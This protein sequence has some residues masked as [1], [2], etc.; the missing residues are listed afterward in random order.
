MKNCKLCGRQYRTGRIAFV[1]AE[2]GLKG[3][4]VCQPC[5]NAGVLLV[6]ARPVV[7]KPAEKGPP[8]S[9][10]VLK[11][12]KAQLKAA[13]AIPTNG[14]EGSTALGTDQFIEGKIEGL[15]N[16]IDALEGKRA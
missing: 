1:M 10:E 15:E 13:K 6:A 11:L 16:A 12:L 2:G 5:A 8:A 3:A 7:R 4:R 14:L 9:A